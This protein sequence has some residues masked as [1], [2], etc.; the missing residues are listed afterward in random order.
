MAHLDSTQLKKGQAALLLSSHCIL[1]GHLKGSSCNIFSL[2]VLML[3][4]H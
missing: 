1:A 4:Q 3:E 2:K